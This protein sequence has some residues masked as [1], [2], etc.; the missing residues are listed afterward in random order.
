MKARP[1]RPAP[2]AFIKP[3]K[4]LGVSA[5]PGP[6]TGPWH[7][8]IKFDGFRAEAVINGGAAVLWS[9]NHKPLAY[10]EIVSALG[11]LPCA[12][13]VL[14]GELVA[15][16]ARGHSNFQALQGAAE[17][18]RPLV[19]FVFDLLHLDGRSLL[20]EP[21]EVRRRALERLLKRA[22]PAV[23]ISP[24]FAVAPAA[25]FTQARRQGLEGIVLKRQGSAYEPDQRSGTW[26]KVKNSNDQEFVIGGFTPPRNS[27][28]HF[29]AILVGYYAGGKLLYAGKVG[30]GFDGKLLRTLHAEFLRLRT[31]RCPFANLPLPHRSRF[32]TGMTSAVM[33]T[34]TW[35][36]PKLVAQIKFA[37]WT[38]ES[39][40]R[41]PVF[42]GLRT[43]KPPG[44]V[45]REAGAQ[46]A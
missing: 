45:R 28:P 24:V 17:G 4:A 8:E 34:V 16:D 19:Y 1:A 2:A 22:G 6:G 38:Q 26:L 46:A 23:R 27:R 32:G 36:R 10:P 44:D 3:M 13:A 35:I 39:L 18:G 12:S 21:I 11:R 40:L 5:V 41:Q 15:L 42:L 9:R 20:G 33:R 37:E 30:T 25:L 29:G 14:D 43:D 31:A 7:G